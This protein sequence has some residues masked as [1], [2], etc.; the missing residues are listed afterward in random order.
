[1]GL[2]DLLNKGKC[3]LGFHDGEW[4][5]ESATSCNFV[6]VCTR[7]KAEHRK[8]EHWWNEW[9]FVSDDACE[10]LRT[11]RRCAQQEQRVTHAWGTPAYVGDA[12][13]EQATECARCHASQVAEVR[14]VMDQ[15]RYT[16]TDTCG[17]VQ[18]CS[19]CQA[20]GSTTRTE[21]LWADW[22]HSNAHSGPVRVCRRCGELEARPLS[23]ATPSAD[24]PTVSDADVADLLARAHA[25]DPASAPATAPVA[26]TDGAEHDTR[27]VGHWRHTEAMSSGGFSS[28][29]DTHFVIDGSGRFARWSHTVGSMGEST[30]ERFDGQWACRAGDLHLTY[31]DGDTS[32]LS[33]DVHA[34]QLF[35]PHGGSQKYWE[36]VR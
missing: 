22:Q 30:S 34:Q 16:S 36:R 15:W 1:M 33:Y 21:H 7:C 19:R 32:L 24:L 20:D 4:I 12:S 5:A 29:T 27:L 2:R 8:V 28:A 10:Q 26:H 35:F 23:V 11:C 13:C 3:L 9:A 31:D 17:Q 6:R 18:Q 25:I 14:H